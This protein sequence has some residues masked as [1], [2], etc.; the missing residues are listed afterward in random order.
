[1]P[2]GNLALLF[3]LPM[4][5]L[6]SSAAEIVAT[7]V[8]HFLHEGELMSANTNP[9]TKACESLFLFL[10]FLFAVAI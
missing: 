6:Y 10:L 3:E 2:V 1:M 8:V 7:E 4:C 5:Y 9:N